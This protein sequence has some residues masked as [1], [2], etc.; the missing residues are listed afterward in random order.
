MT[1][2]QAPDVLCDDKID[3]LSFMQGSVI[4]ILVVF[5]CLCVAII[6]ILLRR[7]QRDAKRE[8]ADEVYPKHSR[9]DHMFETVGSPNYDVDDDKFCRKRQS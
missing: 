1:T 6:V 9:D 4:G 5:V 3:S 2:I 8:L 7:R